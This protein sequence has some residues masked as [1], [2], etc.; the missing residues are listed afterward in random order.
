MGISARSVSQWGNCLGL[1]NDRPDSV[2]APPI[3]TG[4]L[5]PIQSFSTAELPAE[6][7]YVAWLRRDW[8]QAQPIYRTEPTEPFDTRWETAQLGPVT[9]V[10]AEITGMRWERRMED[11]KASDFDPIIVNMMRQGFAEGDM[12][13]RAFR[14]TSGSFHFHDLARPSLHVSSASTTYSLVLQRSLAEEWLGPLHD[15]HGLVVSPPASDMLLEQAARTHGA[16]GRLTAAVAERLGRILLEMVVVALSE[17]RPQIA[18][19]VARTTALR[20]RAREEID[21]RLSET[22]SVAQICRTLGVT[23]AALFAAFEPDGGVQKYAMRARLERARAALADID[24]GEPIGD[25]A[26]RFGFSDAS[27]LS[28]TFKSHF[29]MTPRE[30]RHLAAADQALPE[31]GG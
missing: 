18:P 16:L 20:E 24:R 8:P 25:I 22:V 21:R 5:I 1:T 29:G 19:P 4:E 23:R 28:R 6:Q 31:A 7:R 2:P 30:Y 26:H 3:A 12:D 11:I 13:G 17:E 14:E 10:Y 9:F 27:H 15:L